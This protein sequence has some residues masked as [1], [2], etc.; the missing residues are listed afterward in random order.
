MH[1]SGYQLLY[2]CFELMIEKLKK[3]ALQ[4]EVQ[5][6]PIMGSEYISKIGVRVHLLI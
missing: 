1:V 2:G 4:A 5:P 3:E 6:Q